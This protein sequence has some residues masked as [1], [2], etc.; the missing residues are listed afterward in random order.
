LIISFIVAMD[1]ARGI[2]KGGRLPWRQSADLKRF[3]ALTMGH[4]LVM[5]RKTFETIGR[6]LPGRTMIVITRN[7]DYRPVGA[8][9]VHSI[10]AAL[11]LAE[12]RG[13]TEVFIIGGGEIFTQAFALAE[14]IYLTR[15]HAIS[16]ADVFFPPFEGDDWAILDQISLQEDQNNEYPQTFITLHRKAAA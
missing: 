6:P 15:V 1:E 7:P 8:L 11:A 2:G 13:E 16:E 3:K 9:V 14:R 12:A 4:H 10:Q 5:G